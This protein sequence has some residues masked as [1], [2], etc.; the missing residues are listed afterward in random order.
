MAAVAAGDLPVER[1]NRW[2]KLHD[3]NQANTTI[4][5]GSRGNKTE[6]TPGRRH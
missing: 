6:V 2:R 5:S 3:E 1:L 4:Q